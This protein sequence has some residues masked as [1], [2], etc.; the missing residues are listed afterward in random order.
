MQIANGYV[1]TCPENKHFMRDIT[2]A[3]ALILKKLH[4]QYSNGTPLS[5][6]IITGEA[7]EVDQFGKPL[8]IAKRE[9]F[10]RAIV[11]M[12]N[13]TPVVTNVP[14]FQT[15][16]TPSDKP[17]TQSEEANRIRRKYTGNVTENGKTVSAW[18][19]AFGGGAMPRMPETFDEI[20]HVIGDVFTDG[21]PKVQEPVALPHFEITHADGMMAV[22]EL[23]IPQPSAPTRRGR[24]PL[25]KQPEPLPA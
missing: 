2:P 17:R 15:T 13:G 20:R 12:E 9:A 18:E 5:G 10:S 24:P 19:S 25:V 6:L 11:R 23:M 22:P 16:Y 14:D 3:E 1:T 7:T 21:R 4:N 8:Q